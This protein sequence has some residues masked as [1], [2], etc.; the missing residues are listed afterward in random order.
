MT[1]FLFVLYNI[2]MIKNRLF[3]F[4]A[5]L[6]FSACTNINFLTSEELEYRAYLLKAG[7]ILIKEKRILFWEYL[8]TVLLF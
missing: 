3:Y 7:D 1:L 8:D 4:V 2:D 6:L 5:F